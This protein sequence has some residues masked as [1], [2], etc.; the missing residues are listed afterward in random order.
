ADALP[1]LHLPLIAFFW[2]L[3]VEAHR[4]QRMHDVGRKGFVV[5]GRRCAAR[6]AIP[7][8]VEP[9]AEA[10]E[11]ADAGDPH[12]APLR[13]LASSLI[14]SSSR[15]PQ[16]KNASRNCGLGNAMMRNVS[17]ASQTFLPSRRPTHAATV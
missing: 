17:W 1:H 8:R 15:S 6:Q 11:Q 3:R 4:R 12:L 9:L 10:S 14:G 7:G 16:A 5:V 2:D 13:H